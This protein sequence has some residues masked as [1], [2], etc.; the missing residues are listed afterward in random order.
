[1][2]MSLRFICPLLLVLLNF[3]PCLSAQS[4]WSLQNDWSNASNPN[5]AWT[6]TNNG[7]P[8]TTQYP[9]LDGSLTVPVNAWASSSGSTTTQQLPAWYQALKTGDGGND[10][11]A[12]DIYVH[13]PYTPGGYTSAIWTSPIAG[14]VSVSGEIWHLLNLGRANDWGIYRN[15]VLLTAGTVSDSGTSRTAPILF[16]TGSGGA[17]ALTDIAVNNSDTI[18]FRLWQ[19]PGSPYP[20]PDGVTLNIASPVPEPSTIAILGLSSAF[21]AV[22][23]R[24]RSI[25]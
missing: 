7:T 23:Y 22:I 14:T 3:V 24:R 13:A 12:G 6:L 5:G 15:N 18:E 4:S 25:W 2:N 20:D 1:M 19:N 11:L 16:S 10:Y 17:S 21:L 9:W 8:F